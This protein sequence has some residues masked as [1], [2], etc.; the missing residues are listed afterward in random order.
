MKFVSGALF[1][2]AL[3][4]LGQSALASGTEDSRPAFR[5]YAAFTCAAYAEMTGLENERKRLNEIGYAAGGDFIV[6]IHSDDPSRS[7]EMPPIVATLLKGPNEEVVLQRI[8]AAARKEANDNVVKSNE[9]G[10]PSAPKDWALS[11][12]Q[13]KFRAETAFR[14]ANC[15]LLK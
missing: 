6:S 3:A 10:A 1:G 15:R 14:Q 9:A 13:K 4:G 5:M 2:L 12:D 7:D 8:F 11:L